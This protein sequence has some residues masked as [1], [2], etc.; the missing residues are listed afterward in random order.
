MASASQ[1][2]ILLTIFIAIQCITTL[3]HVPVLIYEN[4]TCPSAETVKATASP[5]VRNILDDNGGVWR[6]VISLNMSDPLQDCPSGW[7]LGNYPRSCTQT[8]GPGCSL[9]T[10]AVNNSYSE[11]R[12]RA[13]GIATGSIGAFQSYSPYRR[14]FNYADGMNIFLAT[15]TPQHVWT[16]AV[17]QERPNLPRSR[18]PCSGSGGS[19]N[20][21]AYVGSHYFCDTRGTNSWTSDTVVWDGTGCSAATCCVNNPPWFSVS[22]NTTYTQDIQ[23]RLCT[24]EN[25]NF[26][27]I[28][29]TELEIFVQ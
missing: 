20:F 17:D 3:R 21:P 4:G 6:L 11:V 7:S 13:V 18:C 24:D 28:S 1:Y 14:G 10:F 23:V 9:A 19:Y 12:G 8:T 15:A 27:R 2:L 22:F 5:I 25:F 16:F 26:E 29:L